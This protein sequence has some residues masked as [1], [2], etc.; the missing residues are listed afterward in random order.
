MLS[1][2]FSQAVKLAFVGIVIAIIG[3][4]LF[5]NFFDVSFGLGTRGFNSQL[6]S[7]VGVSIKSHSDIELNENS[8]IAIAGED[9]KVCVD[10]VVYLDASESKIPEGRK[11][12]SYYWDVNDQDAEN[13]TLGKK[14]ETTYSEE[15]NYYATLKVIGD[16]EHLSEDTVYIQVYEKC[17][18]KYSPQDDIYEDDFN[19]S[20]E[21]PT[22]IDVA[23]AKIYVSSVEDNAGNSLRDLSVSLNDEVYPFWSKLNQD[24]D[25]IEVIEFTE[26]IQAILDSEN[27]LGNDFSNIKLRFNLSGSGIEGDLKINQLAIPFEYKLF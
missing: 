26:E 7:K 21:V 14:Q 1:K 22:N 3:F 15:G 6:L 27:E 18:N 24:L 13:F 4:L 17:I 8:V 5:F 10:E 25:E 9:Q 23:N 16:D 2:G 11:I 20:I 12:S 19:I